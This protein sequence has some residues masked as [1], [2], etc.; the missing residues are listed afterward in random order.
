MGKI[1][2]ITVALV[3]FVAML[4]DPT[5]AEGMRGGFYSSLVASHSARPSQQCI[6]LLRSTCKCVGSQDKLKCRLDCLAR[7]M[8]TFNNDCTGALGKP[9]CRRRLKEC[10]P[11]M[12][13]VCGCKNV[14]F[15][16]RT[17]CFR[18]CFVVNM[19]K[20]ERCHRVRTNCHKIGAFHL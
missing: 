7:N 12:R 11:L 20:L 17:L 1:L 3:F 19:D 6:S 13:A 9:L 15:H 4:I 2:P 8:D 18:N 16:Q 14:P 5:A 10:L